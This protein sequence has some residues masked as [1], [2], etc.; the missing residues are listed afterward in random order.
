MA[1]CMQL[2]KC[3]RIDQTYNTTNADG[4][5]VV[6]NPGDFYDF[7]DP[8]LEGVPQDYKTNQCSPHPLVAIIYFF[9]YILIITFMLLQVGVRR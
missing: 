8:V 6:L 5:P 4:D 2:D 1:D 3:V 9:S 7:D